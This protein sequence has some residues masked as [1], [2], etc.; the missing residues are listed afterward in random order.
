MCFK[1]NNKN[2]QNAALVIST[3]TGGQRTLLQKKLLV[4]FD[5][6]NSESSKK[7]HNFENL[8]IINW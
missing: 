1:M 4:L 3:G 2:L 8:S 6:T 7:K 5:L